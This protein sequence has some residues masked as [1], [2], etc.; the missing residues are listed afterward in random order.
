MA[1]IDVKITDLTQVSA[2][3]RDD[4]FLISHPL[5]NAEGAL[6]ETPY[7]SNSLS[8]GALSSSL[9][10]ML[11]GNKL[12]VTGGD[13]HFHTNIENLPTQDFKFETDD[14]ISA[15]ENHSWLTSITNDTD[16]AGWYHNLSTSFVQDDDK[17][18]G[19]AQSISAMNNSVPNVD[20]VQRA[21]AGAYQSLLN[22]LTNIINQ[23]ATYIPSHVG[24]IIHSTR[25]STEE[26]VRNVYGHGQNINGIQYPDTH[27]IKHS[28]YFLRGAASGVTPSTSTSGDGAKNV[29]DDGDD[30]KTFK[31]T[32]D[33][34]PSHSHRL[35]N[36]QGGASVSGTI[37]N[38]ITSVKVNSTVKADGVVASSQ[39]VYPVLTIGTT[40]SNV[41]IS[42]GSISYSSSAKTNDTGLSKNISLNV[43]PSYK[44]V[45]IWER[46]S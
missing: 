39:A 11:E 33:Q 24:E 21:I 26:L 45:Y 38:V 32:I 14:F 25:L 4:L 35:T 9:R 6:Q 34:L 3:K 46:I 22:Q 44:N 8:G 29:K 43:V 28:G 20:F 30:V 2:V 17:R 23:N 41:S 13:W 40:K 27:W 1:Y 19:A 36:S 15:L 12:C 37:E 10:E 7:T 31:L 5:L 42:S 16:A 18:S